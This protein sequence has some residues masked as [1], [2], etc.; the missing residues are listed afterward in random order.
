MVFDTHS[1]G[2]WSFNA[3]ASVHDTVS[4]GVVKSVLP[5]VQQSAGTTKVQLRATS[6]TPNTQLTKPQIS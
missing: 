1:D 5:P 3:V 6:N 4:S 2:K